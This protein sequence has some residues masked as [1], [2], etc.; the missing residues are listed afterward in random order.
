M[1]DKKIY[2]D[3]MSLIAEVQIAESSLYKNLCDIGMLLNI[4]HEEV[5]SN[6]G[7]FV[8]MY[9]DTMFRQCFQGYSSDSILNTLDN[10]IKKI[11]DDK[12]KYI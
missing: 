8:S 6:D 10:L 11:E 3:C 9:S 12:K 4:L 5:N 1:N 7:K 2:D